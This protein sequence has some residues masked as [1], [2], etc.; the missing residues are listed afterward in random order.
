M[1]LPSWPMGLSFS[2]LIF[3]SSCFVTR[4][5]AQ[6]VTSQEQRI[7]AGKQT[8]VNNCAACHGEDG[9]ATAAQWA[10]AFWRA[11]ALSRGKPYTTLL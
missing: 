4:A 9:L 8:F 1:K 3:L 5:N 6:T 10:L 7:S 2:A 11:R